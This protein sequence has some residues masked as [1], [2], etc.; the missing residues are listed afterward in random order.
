MNT[1]QQQGYDIKH[2]HL[3]LVTD[4]SDKQSRLTRSP[5]LRRFSRLCISAMASH[6]L[7]SPTGRIS[8]AVK[9]SYGVDSRSR[10]KRIIPPCFWTGSHMLSWIFLENIP[11]PLVIHKFSRYSD[12]EETFFSSHMG[13][14]NLVITGSCSLFSSGEH[15][16]RYCSVLSSCHV[17][18]DLCR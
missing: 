10:M 12:M 18:P 17:T 13:D 3:L 6:S 11:S 8:D 5:K 15:R 14:I 4:P 16:E 2:N 1:E 9:R 7:S